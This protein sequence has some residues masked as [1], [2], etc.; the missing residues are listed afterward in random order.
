MNNRLIKLLSILYLKFTVYF[1]LKKA[2]QSSATVDHAN[3]LA[4]CT[5]GRGSNAKRR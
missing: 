4:S 1:T 5:D 3:L 2:N